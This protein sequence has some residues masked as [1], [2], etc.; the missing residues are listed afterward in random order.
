MRIA[1]SGYPTLLAGN[2]VDTQKRQEIV[3]NI[4]HPSLLWAKPGPGF[5]TFDPF[6]ESFQRRGL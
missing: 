4:L 2:K 5:P 3:S 6:P 1:V